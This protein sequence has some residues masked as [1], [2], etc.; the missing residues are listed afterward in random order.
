MT[1]TWTTK[2]TF[3]GLIVCTLVT[4]SLAFS[5]WAYSGTMTKAEILSKIIGNT[6]TGTSGGSTYSEY[7][8]PDGVVHGVDSKSGK[9]TARW[10]IRD[11]DLMCWATPPNFAIEGCVLLTI[12]GDTVTYQL[13]N[14]STEGPV[15]LHPG[16]PNNL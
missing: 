6:V 3:L 8:T 9:Y 7:Y 15:K 14:G 13:I 1:M 12:S 4:P 5:H 2:P 11:D 16:N 10:S